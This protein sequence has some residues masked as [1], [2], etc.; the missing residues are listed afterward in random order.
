M[1]HR[2]SCRQ[3]LKHAGD[4]ADVAR[5]AISGGMLALPTAVAKRSLVG[6]DS[7]NRRRQAYGLLGWQKKLS[8]LDKEF[9]KNFL[10]VA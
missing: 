3:D 8:V 5:A 9:L 2:L 6:P 4:V 10:G 1:L 7:A